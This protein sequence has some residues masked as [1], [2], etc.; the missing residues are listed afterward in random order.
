M[1]TG[2]TDSKE[3]EEPNNMADIRSYMREKEKREKKQAGYKAKIR[4]HKLA[5]VYRILLVAAATVALV[6]LVSVQYR[7]HVYTA[8]DVVA[9]V[10][11]ENVDDAADIRL[12]SAILTYSR[13]G[14]HCTDAKGTVAWNQ[15]YEMQ[16]ERL[17]VCGDTVA[18]GDY[19]GRSIYVQNAEKQLGEITTTMPIRSVTVS[20]EGN[21][22]AVLA[23]TDVTW[24]NTYNAKGELLYEGQTHMGD[25]GYPGSVSL[26][27]SGELLCVAYVYVDAGVLKTNN[28]FY[29]FGPVGANNSDYIVS[30]Y[31]Y[32]D[33][34]VPYVQFMNDT[35]AFAV[36]DSCL[37]I[38]SGG[39]KPVEKAQY[40]F[41][42][43]VQS[44][45]YS[46]SYIG[47]IFRSEQENVQYRMDVYDA[48]ASK[49]GSYDINIEYTDVFFE[50]DRFV[51]YNDR[52]CLIVNL[53][54]VEK[55]S[56][57]FTK[58]VRL[59]LPAK[60]AYRYVLVTDTSIDT[61]QLK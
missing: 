5:A 23:D 25:A 36:G 26:S 44:V 9:T 38:Y 54:G 45:Y 47:M 15:T 30:A 4:R 2:V 35:T 55:F 39:Q 21:V 46:D 29:N 52:E 58:Q 59:M 6:A 31:A 3:A 19:N 34:L 22:T 42:E 18:I 12:G 57:T 11:R 41:N 27:P 56:G 37:M 60:G 61:I 8:Y 14:A 49:V 40:H 53:D 28:V 50:Q 51:A 48:E 17:A 33:M 32:T 13:D 16:D 43:E 24:V 7:R 20:D 10:P 1:Q